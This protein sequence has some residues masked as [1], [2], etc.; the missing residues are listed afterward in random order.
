MQQIDLEHSLS[1]PPPTEPNEDSR[2]GSQPM[3][4][5]PVDKE[6]KV[7]NY[8]VNGQTFVLTTIQNVSGASKLE[9]GI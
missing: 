8:D 3:E 4:V 9:N 5:A 6:E 7:L 2:N 1:S